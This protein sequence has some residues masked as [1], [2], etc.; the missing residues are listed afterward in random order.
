[1]ALDLRAGGVWVAVHTPFRTDGALD[2]QGIQA[3][4]H[5]Y[6]D[7]LGLQGVF[8]NG[9]FGEHWALTLEE[10][11]RIAE[12][13]ARAARG[14][15][16][17]SPNCTHHS[18]AETID[19]ARHA[20]ASGCEYVVLMNPATSPRT[21]PE[22]F[23]WFRRVADAV[24][25]DLFI[26]NTSAPG[27]TLAPELIARLA[28]TGRFKVLKAAGGSHEVTE[29]RRLV[30]DRIIVSDPS[31]GSWLGNLIAY[32]QRLLY[33]DAEP[34]LYQSGKDHPI[35]RML[36]AYRQ[37]RVDEVI[38]THR[39]LAPMRAVYEEWISGPVRRGRASCAAIKH[40]A[41][42]RGF[43]AGPVR[44]P[45]SPLSPNEGEMLAQALRAV[46]V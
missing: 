43:A 5:R 30:G 21:E 23:D 9:L 4:I 2:E 7:E 45:L 3:N 41:A 29:A 40:W 33:A 11:K 17:L 12:A 15:I 26:F 32:D 22:L 6:A 38:A 42:R 24:K 34:Y 19:L 1:M 16:A 13:S 31:E 37:G 8:F 25:S 20:E 18:L 10:R 39:S 14:R 46:G 35:Q 44:P 36:D 27:Y 28:A